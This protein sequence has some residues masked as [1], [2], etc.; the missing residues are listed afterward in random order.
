[1]VNSFEPR[2]PIVHFVIFVAESIVC[3]VPFVAKSS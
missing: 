1:M 3:L 2:T